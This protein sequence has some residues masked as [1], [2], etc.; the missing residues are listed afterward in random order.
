MSIEQRNVEYEQHHVEKKY[1][2]SRVAS[3]FIKYAAYVLIFFGVLY[4][5]AKYI[6]PKF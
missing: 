4:F 6:I 2:S 3:T 1:D 5:L